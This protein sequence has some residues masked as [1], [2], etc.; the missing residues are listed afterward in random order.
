MD[1]A[2]TARVAVALVICATLAFATNAAAED[3]TRWLERAA[4]A[5]KTLNYAG[6]V[7]FQHNGH[8]ETSRLVHMS[9]NGQEQEKLVSLD[10][11]AREVIRS[12]NDVRSYFPDAKVVRV[13]PTNNLLLIRGAVPGPNGG[14]I[15]IRQT[16]MV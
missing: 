2:P 6:T 9:D 16:N 14:Y 10:G 15:T 13:D 4:L 1:R 5:A 8:V 11:P 12:S 3:A 7:V